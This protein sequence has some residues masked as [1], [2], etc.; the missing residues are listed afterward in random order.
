[1]VAELLVNQHNKFNTEF[2][3]LI[4]LVCFGFTKLRKR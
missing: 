1:M 3:Y 4:I 2:I